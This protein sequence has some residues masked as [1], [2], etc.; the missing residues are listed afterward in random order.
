MGWYGWLVLIEYNW[1]VL[2]SFEDKPFDCV[3]EDDLDQF[4]YS[5]EEK[6]TKHMLFVVYIIFLSVMGRQAGV[7][8]IR[9]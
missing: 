4:W 2:N 5:Y 6:N 8:I 9:A 3:L 7:Q 1:V